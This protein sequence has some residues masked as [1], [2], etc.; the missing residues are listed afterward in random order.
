MQRVAKAESKISLRPALGPSGYRS[1]ATQKAMK[2]TKTPWIYNMSAK[3]QRLLAAPGKSPHGL[4]TAIDISGVSGA[5]LS[6]LIKNAKRFGFSRPLPS[7]DP[8]HFVHDGHTSTTA[9]ETAA[10]KRARAA[11]ERLATRKAVA[12]Y[13]NRRPLGVPKTNTSLDGKADAKYWRRLASANLIDGLKIATRA[14]REA[15]YA[16][17][18]K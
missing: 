14:G 12:L 15:H 5:R 3:T 1:L 13:L 6:W 7:S 11:R 2:T 10:E 18:A 4:G 9:P 17:I 8:A 16:K